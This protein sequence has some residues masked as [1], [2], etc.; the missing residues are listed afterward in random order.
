[1]S[2]GVKSS[3]SKRNFCTSCGERLSREARFCAACGSRVG[4]D[5]G[6]PVAKPART[7]A[8][9]VFSAFVAVGAVALWFALR[10]SEPPARAVPGTPSAAAPGGPAG[11]PPSELPP[12]HPPLELP[13]E[14]I[15]FLAELATAAEAAPTDLEAWQKLARA[16]YRAAL[17]DPS[18]VTP[19]TQ[20][21]DRVLELDRDNLE[22]VRTRGN[23][24]Y[25][26]RDYRTAQTYFER[27]LTLDPSEPSVKTDLASTL[28]FQGEREKAKELYRE[29]IAK[30][31]DF[32]QAHLNLGIALH[33]DGDREASKKALDTAL[34]RA[35]T[36]EQRA[37]VERVIALAAER[38]P[39]SATAKSEAAPAPSNA[40]AT[41]ATTTFQREAEGVLRQHPIV[42][43]KIEAV[44]WN[45][46]GSATVLLRA[47]PMQAMPPVMR[48]KFKSRMNES[49][50]ALA[51]RDGVSEPLRIDLADAGTKER[52]DTL[53]GKEWV[54][55]FDE[56]QAQ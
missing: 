21:L 29:V 7:A 53:D 39:P 15:A 40:A 13:E 10:A 18:Y 42:G 8:A 48:N 50:A 1:M 2:E 12:E 54:G 26:T 9:T 24:A 14:A 28:L 31:P 23:L 6:G 16:R 19:A 49:L 17:I 30:S 11:G 47:F 44:E 36:P 25:D 35:K 55:A 33:A 4:S 38:A 34:E 52:M 45:G 27:Y 32:V 43:P 20:A 3:A 56:D 51:A 5:A 46:P 37:Q 22:G 41:N